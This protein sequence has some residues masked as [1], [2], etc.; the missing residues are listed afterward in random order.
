MVGVGLAGMQHRG[1][2]E[3]L[4]IAGFEVHLD[5]EPRVIG[6]RLGQSQRVAL[7]RGQPGGSGVALRVADVPGDEEQSRDTVDIDD[8]R[9]FE[10]RGFPGTL[11]IV[12]IPLH[13]PVHDIDEIRRPAQHLVIDRVRADDLGF[14]TRAR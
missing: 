13:R 5:M 6:D 7:L 3:Q 2:V 8:R 10:E 9:K 12:A 11:L 1:V 14:A 4:D